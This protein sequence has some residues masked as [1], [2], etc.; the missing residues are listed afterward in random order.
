LDKTGIELAGEYQPTLI[1]PKSKW[2]KP[3]ILP[4][5]ATG[6]HITITPL[7][8]AMLYNAIANNGRMMKPYLIHSVREYGQDVKVTEPVVLEESIADTASIRQLQACAEE[9]VL[10]GTGH[11]IESPFYKMA[12]KTGTA[13]VYDPSKDISYKSGV[14]Q[15]TFVGYFPAD[16]PR[17]TICVVIRT[18]PRAGTYYGG[19]L[20][21]PVFRM[22]ADKIFA[23]GL[24]AWEGPL[25][26]LSRI[27]KGAMPAKAT[28]AAHFSA[29]L[30]KLGRQ[31]EAPVKGSMLAQLQV[32]TAVKKVS[33]APRFAPKG[34][35]PDVTGMGL[36]DALFLLEKE[37]L[38]VR[39]QG[40]GAVQMQSITPGSAFR[41]GETIIL[42]LG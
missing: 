41:K 1:S 21:A 25:D 38:H 22:V 16:K 17:Y 39:V 42:Q 18:L 11:H 5:L 12:G 31:A 15:G 24:G 35:V 34:L 40:S 29:L 10:T 8:T 7:H 23:S 36:R 13:Q 33:I 14:Y 37:G 32:D 6:Y 4:W 3:I 20:S 30:G 27:S 9:V 26:S 28:T 2:W 19:T